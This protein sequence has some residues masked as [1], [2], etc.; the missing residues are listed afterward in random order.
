[1]INKATLI[2]RLGKDPELFKTS[3]G[4][5]ILR[6]SLATSERWK[7]KEGQWAERTEWHRITLFGPRVEGVSKY[8]K[9]GTMIYVEGKI[10]YHNY[11]DKNGTKQY[12]TEI[13][14]EDIQILDKIAKESG[15]KPVDA[16][17]EKMAS[18]T[19][20]L[21]E[22]TFGPGVDEIPF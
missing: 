9:K 15:P 16:A 19:R 10:H 13:V 17:I 20:Q 21:V 4:S 8:L 11:E 3:T 22:D 14:V 1:M 2:G 12:L 5:P 6:A 7:D 18:S